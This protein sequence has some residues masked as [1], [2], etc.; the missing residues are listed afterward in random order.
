MTNPTPASDFLLEDPRF[1]IPD[2][3]VSCS[4]KMN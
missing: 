3:R 4:V 2:D 1:S